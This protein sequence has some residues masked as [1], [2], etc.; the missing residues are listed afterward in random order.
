MPSID[1]LLNDY[2]DDRLDPAARRRLESALQS[3]ARLAE[4]LRGL[5][6]VRNLVAALPRETPS[7]VAPRVL[8]RI[9]A[10]ATEPGRIENPRR[11][12]GARTAVAAALAASVMALAGAVLFETRRGREGRPPANHG[13]LAVADE[14][15]IP[16]PARLAAAQTVQ[17]RPTAAHPAEPDSPAPV[18]VRR[19]IDNPGLHRVFSVSGSDA[20]ERRI[21]SVVAQT[22]RYNYLK[23]SIAQG[24]VIDPRHPD[25]ASVYA[26]VVSDQEI[27]ALRDRLRSVAGEDAVAEAEV[28]PA[29]AVQLAEITVAQAFRPTPRADVLIP[30]GSLALRVGD[31]IPAGE[32]AADDARPDS[33]QPTPEQFRSAP[34]AAEIAAERAGGHAPSSVPPTP[35]SAP[36]LRV[37]LVWVARSPQGG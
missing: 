36:P 11:R 5:T 15:R 13:P 19:F 7:D 33:D 22:T 18:I 9:A 26:V 28:D 14:G 2:L 3:D 17:P 23:L 27:D 37:V 25:Q 1:S 4:S 30:A 10:L 32:A 12:P 35:P 24:I 31:P 16:A 21:A 29:V 6:E 20:V 8:A 34:V